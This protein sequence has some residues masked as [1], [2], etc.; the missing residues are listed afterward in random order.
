M[1]EIINR[2]ANRDNSA[3]G[4]YEKDGVRYCGTC[5]KPKTAIVPGISDKPI[6]VACDC[7]AKEA[8]KCKNDLELRQFMANIAA[9]QEKFNITDN[10]Y[11]SMTFERDDRSDLKASN[12]SRKYVEHWEQIKQD[13]TGILFY[14]MVGTGKTFYGCS[15]VNALLARKVRATVTNFPRLLNLLQSASDRQGLID[16]LQTYELLVIDDLGVERDSSFAAEQ[17]FSVI[18]ARA[19]SGLPLI[20]TTN[21]TL[22]ELREPGSM[23]YARIYDRLL[24]MCRVH[25]KMTGESKRTQNAKEKEERAKRLLGLE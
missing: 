21:M 12:A 6:P 1:N 8:V 2:L 3:P 14:G 11:K 7:E 18:D 15:I 23:Q 24:G 5:H 16:H 20:V 22:K 4:D 10:A 9:D 19:R 13:N 25:L 17:V